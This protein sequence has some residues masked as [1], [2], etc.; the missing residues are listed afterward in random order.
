MNTVAMTVDSSVADTV[1]S[2]VTV[3]MYCGQHCI[4][5]LFMASGR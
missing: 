3:A 5:V 2:L 4:R 1:F